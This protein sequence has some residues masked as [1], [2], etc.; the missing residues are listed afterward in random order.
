[1]STYTTARSLFKARS[2][3]RQQA[4]KERALLAPFF[5][6]NNRSTFP[7]CERSVGTYVRGGFLLALHADIDG[8]TRPRRLLSPTDCTHNP[9]RSRHHPNRR[10]NGDQAIPRPY[11]LFLGLLL[12]LLSSSLISRVIF[13]II[14]LVCL[15]TVHVCLVVFHLF[16]QRYL[17][18]DVQTCVSNGGKKCDWRRLV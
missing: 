1:M 10:V 4:L 14:S 8:D 15:F 17:L 5:L 7:A 9:A 16:T 11:V 13:F 6:G 18:R 12:L 3:R 2:I